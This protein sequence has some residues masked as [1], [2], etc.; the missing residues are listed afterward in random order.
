[1]WTRHLMSLPFSCSIHY[2]FLG[3]AMLYLWILCQ[4][5]LQNIGAICLACRI[6][7]CT[8][9]VYLGF[10]HDKLFAILC[11]CYFFLCHYYS[12]DGFLIDFVAAIACCKLQLLLLKASVA[13]CFC[14]ALYFQYCTK[15]DL[16]YEHYKNVPIYLKDYQLNCL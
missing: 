15:I 1:M 11:Y 16:F 6:L 2:K 7:F 5:W 14:V 3:I 12:V 4:F 9:Q 13:A 8:L 10:E